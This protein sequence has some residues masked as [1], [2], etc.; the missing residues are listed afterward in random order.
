M[1]LRSRVSC[2]T[3]NSRRPRVKH[4]RAV[5]A[6]Y[7][8]THGGFPLARSSNA[9]GDAPSSPPPDTS[10]Q[11]SNDRRGVRADHPSCMRDTFRPGPSCQGSRVG[12][13]RQRDPALVASS[14]CAQ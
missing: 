6:A 1:K 9:R 4:C 3:T 5:G 11:R 10:T 14:R 8:V 7:R 2:T 12:R 13:G